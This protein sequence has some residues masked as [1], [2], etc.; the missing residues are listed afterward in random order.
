M[1]EVS[2]VEDFSHLERLDDGDKRAKDARAAVL[3][4]RKTDRR[5]EVHVR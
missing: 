4:L 5:F 3:A 2:N 1:H